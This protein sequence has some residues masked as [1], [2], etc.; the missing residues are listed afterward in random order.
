LH[1]PDR[2]IRLECPGGYLQ[3]EEL[4][5]GRR[6]LR[7][8]PDD[9][10]A[11]VA[12]RTWETRYPVDLIRLIAGVKGLN[13]V[14]DEI[15]REED[16]GYLQH[17]LSWTLRAHVNVEDV[18]SG[19]ILDFGCG[20]GSST[21]ILARMFP[22]AH[23]VGV[24]IDA[25]TQQI[26]EAR[27]EHFGVA[28]AEFRLSTDATGVPD[29]LGE[30]DFIVFSALFEHLLPRE[31][32]RV[33]PAVWSHL[34]PGGLLFL[35]ETPHRYSP[36]EIH[37]TGGLP[38]VNYLPSPLALRAARRFSSRIEPE[39]TWQELL[40]RGMRGGTEREFMG[41]LSKAGFA[42]AIIERP[43]KL[44]LRDEFDLWYEISQ[45]NELPGFKAR[46][47]TAFRVLRRISGVSFTPY[48]AF[49]VRREATLSR[50]SA[51]AR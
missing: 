21:M 49:A 6:S 44:G 12:E 22:D 5:G 27:R 8:V 29:D 25:N 9:D 39:D 24:D 14:C 13:A 30:Y 48:L 33:I 36:I 10:S 51:A 47:R 38:L 23:I 26:A 42:D 20:G 40:R 17:V 7:A 15:R 34:R 37:T 43:S 4:G 32:V 1:D 16:P 3:V 18:G 50:R 45:V 35:A 19:R 31:R 28:R 46:L 2:T 41:Y 11:F